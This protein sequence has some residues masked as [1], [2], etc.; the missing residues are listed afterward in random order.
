MSDT[1][2]LDDVLGGGAPPSQELEAVVLL[3]AGSYTSGTFTWGDGY[4]HSDFDYVV[5]TSTHGE[6][7]YT[8][9]TA[10]ST[11]LS[12]P[13][14]RIYAW[15]SYSGITRY[16][17]IFAVSDSSINITVAD[18]AAVYSVVGYKKRYATK[19]GSK[20]IYLN[21]AM[22]GT[23]NGE[24]VP[25]RKYDINIAT[26][27]GQEW[28]GENLIVR[29]EV[30]ING[31]WGVANLGEIYSS[32]GGNFYQY[33][34]MADVGDGVVE[35]VTGGYGTLESQVAFIV[36]GTQTN[37]WDAGHISSAPCRVKVWKSSQYSL[38][39]ESSGGVTSHDDL[40]E[41]DTV[42][43]HTA[44]A[45]TLPDNTS[46][47]DE[48]LKHLNEHKLDASQLLLSNALDVVHEE[49]TPS[50]LFSLEDDIYRSAPLQK[51]AVVV[52]SE[53]K[54]RNSVE[55]VLLNPE[56]ATV[57]TLDD[58]NASGSGLVLA[59]D[60]IQI[61][62]TDNDWHMY[63]T[64]PLT[65]SARE[66]GGVS[67]S[68]PLTVRSEIL[69]NGVAT[70]VVID[71]E[72]TQNTSTVVKSGKVTSGT[73]AIVDGDVITLGVYFLNRNTVNA[74]DAINIATGAMLFIEIQGEGL[75]EYGIPPRYLSAKDYKVQKVDAQPIS[76]SGVLG[77]LLTYDASYQ[78][79][80][81]VD[82]FYDSV[83]D[84]H[85]I[86]NKVRT[87]YSVHISQPLTKSGGGGNTGA[88]QAAVIIEKSTDSTDGTDGTWEQVFVPDVSTNAR[89]LM[90]TDG[91]QA[92]ADYEGAVLF[93]DV[94][95]YRLKFYLLDT[96]SGSVTSTAVVSETDVDTGY[97]I[98]S[99]GFV[100]ITETTQR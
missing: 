52:R 13:D 40:T 80:N 61:T 51:N 89:I 74:S 34:V 56:T 43:A 92:T 70:G 48:A 90:L 1:V 23:V 84:A 20:T 79:R 57:I 76:N 50:I 94:G 53:A 66:G 49:G 99:A 30:L 68:F 75:I 9:N 24:V 21:D 87:A 65:V 96:D 15:S 37:K 63:A 33:G 54:A 19:D 60:G 42:G 62:D 41:L 88:V 45:I 39:I 22:H 29:A 93:T 72:F 3:P 27:L 17:G 71:T 82:M 55:Q 4:K 38:D 95:Y 31:E 77:T 46:T 25:R 59:T 5:I 16:A 6:N 86:L 81:N 14:W 18:N 69:V 35:V 12:L 11:L 28:L 78:S 67:T 2:D 32:S 73:L 36:N 100:R 7:Q 98:R 10:D 44:A 97:Q 8:S 91:G 26:E 85:V 83:N 58:G 47:V 64:V